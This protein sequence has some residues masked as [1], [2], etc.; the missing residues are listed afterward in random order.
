MARTKKKELPSTD[1]TYPDPD[2]SFNPSDFDTEL[3]QTAAE[4]VQSVADSTV[5]PDSNGYAARTQAPGH[6][7]NPSSKRRDGHAAGV[8]KL[9]GKFGVAAGDLWVHMIDKGDNRAGIGIRVEVPEGRTLTDDEKAIIRLHVKGE[10]GEQTGFAW[11][12]DNGMWRKDIVRPGEH[13][14][15]VPRTRPVAIRM[16]AERRVET[17]GAALRQHSVDPVG[18]AEMIRQQREQASQGHGIPD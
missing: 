13:I 11:D 3:Q 6:I 18:Y 2:T 9:P 4:I 12:R 8:R 16:D 15:D 1:T 14:D 17:L 10:E 5:P 7:A